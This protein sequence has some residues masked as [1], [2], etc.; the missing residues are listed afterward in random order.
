MLNK[1]FPAVV[2]VLIT[3]LLSS[4]SLS[5][6]VVTFS[7]TELPISI[8]FA[9]NSYVTEPLDSDFID[10]Y[11]GK[12]KTDWTEENIIISTYFR[13]GSAGELNIGFEG[14]NKSGTSTI[15]FTVDGKRS[16]ER[17]VGKE[18]RY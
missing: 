1:L 9:G 13:V 6:K 16:E 7:E 8:P 11:S 2:F 15:R 12:F 5:N 18:C 14:S 3:L 17:R 10:N 4:C